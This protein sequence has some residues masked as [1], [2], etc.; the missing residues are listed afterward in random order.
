GDEVFLRRI[1]LDLIGVQ[2][3]PD[4]IAAF[5]AHKDP[6]KREKLADALFARPE[7]VDHW[8]LKWGDLLQNSRNAA[9]SPAV[10]QFR[11][12]LRGA[13]ASNLPMDEFA[14]KILT[15]RGG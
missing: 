2:P 8:S 15:S 3:K 9:S 12:F 5:V 6:K 1:Y 14:K 7:F 11:E 4:E 13:I 10:F